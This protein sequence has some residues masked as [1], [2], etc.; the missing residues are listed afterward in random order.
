MKFRV[1]G[2]LLSDGPTE[3]TIMD[4]FNGTIIEKKFVSPGE[5]YVEFEMPN[6]C[7]VDVLARCGKVYMKRT[8]ICPLIISEDTQRNTCVSIWE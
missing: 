3:I 2:E 1:S 6:F 7:V 4:A 8:G 5:Y